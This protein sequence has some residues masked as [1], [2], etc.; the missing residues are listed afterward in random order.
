MS[1]ALFSLAVVVAEE[2]KGAYCVFY[3][4]Y[5][6]RIAYPKKQEVIREREMIQHNHTR[7]LK[8]FAEARKPVAKEQ[9]DPT[10]KRV[11]FLYDSDEELP[12]VPNSRTERIQRLP[13]A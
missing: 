11:P 13:S 4:I 6:G 12:F 7:Q 10:T 5:R 9:S 3:G 1:I 8:Q 2:E